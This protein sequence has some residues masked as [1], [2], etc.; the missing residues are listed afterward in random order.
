MSFLVLFS[1][2]LCAIVFTV[3][4][5]LFLFKFQRQI[6][7]FSVTLFA[8]VFFF[9]VVLYFLG[10]VPY[11]TDF[12][13]IL[14][15][16][17]RSIVSAASMFVLSNNYNDIFSIGNWVISEPLFNITFF[18][19]H[20]AAIFV[21]ATAAFSIFGNKIVSS[22]RLF[23]KFD[24]DLYIIFGA[25]EKSISFAKGLL[26][27]HQ[28]SRFVQFID[29]NFESQY[30]E[31]ILRIG[32]SFFE[33][34]L[35]DNTIINKSMA[36]RIALNSW[37]NHKKIFVVAFT[38]DDIININIISELFRFA[39]TKKLNSEK[40]SFYLQAKSGKAEKYFGE[41]L[42]DYKNL[43]DEE[44]YE[45]SIFNEADL[46]IQSLLNEH[47]LHQF[48]P[49]IEGTNIPKESP[50]VLIIGFG[51]VGK[52]ALLEL[53]QRG[54]FGPFQA[55]GLIFAKNPFS[56]TIIDRNHLNF[57]WQYQM[58]YPLLKDFYHLEFVNCDV[59]SQEFQKLLSKQYH[60]ILIALGD[61]LLNM[62]VSNDIE[63]Y[64]DELGQQPFIAVNLTNKNNLIGSDSKARKVEHVVY[65]GD[66]DEVFTQ[67]IIIGEERYMNAKLIHLSYE[68]YRSKNNLTEGFIPKTAQMAS[69]EWKK[70]DYFSKQSNL[71]AAVHMNIKLYLSNIEIVPKETVSETD[72]ATMSTLDQYLSAEMIEYLAET[73]HMR[74]NAFHITR[75][76]RTMRLEECK[77]YATRKDNISCKHI[78]IV[79][80]TLLDSV[81]DYLKNVDQSYSGDLKSLDREVV[82]N[83]PKHFYDPEMQYDSGLRLKIKGNEGML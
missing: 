34:S 74:W 27:N 51:N 25:N 3:I 40:I 24:K 62:E 33:E 80:W 39:K 83:I 66:Y 36:G 60:Y 69:C 76:W 46:A 26:M 17:L 22:I 14:T 77:S 79:D 64:Y 47:P 13:V 58:H 20:I 67:E 78:A 73:E 19:T 53:I 6:Q 4:F 68:N 41:F 1:M 30:S 10:Y 63:R 48:L 44:T 9:G 28:D 38:E 61:D 37:R 50:S 11:S 16:F 70:V 2:F 23:F 45:V 29:Q 59:K 75:G 31:E 43:D 52:F 56:A 12:T 7:R 5:A 15:T 18:L 49:K 42:N 81:N 55:N 71:A 35:T 57:N 72:N 32:G 82:L 8:L 54:Q 21:T 65:F